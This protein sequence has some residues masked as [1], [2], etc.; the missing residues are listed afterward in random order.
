MR[1]KVC[2]QSVHTFIPSEWKLGLV[3]M[4]CNLYCHC[5]YIISCLGGEWTFHILEIYFNCLAFDIWHLAY[6]I[7]HST[8]DLIGYYGSDRKIHEI[9]I[10]V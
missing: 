3:C 6:G 5:Q 4:K 7:Q 2:T 1:F 9:V 8:M 10:V